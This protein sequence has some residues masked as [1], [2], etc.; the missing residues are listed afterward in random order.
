MA[1]MVMHLVTRFSAVFTTWA[2]Q[3]LV[4][5]Q[6]IVRTVRPM[7]VGSVSTQSL[8][9]LFHLWKNHLTA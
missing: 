2:I 7:A 3:P 1:P 4:T 6:S 9:I 8:W 5:P